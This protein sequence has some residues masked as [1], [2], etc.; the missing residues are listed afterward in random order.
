MFLSRL[1]VPHLEAAIAASRGDL[2]VVGAKCDSVD[3]DLVA[4]EDHQGSAIG[5]IPYPGSVVPT[6][7]HKTLTVCTEGDAENAAGMA[8]QRAELS[9]IRDVPHRHDLVH[10]GAGDSTAVRTESDTLERRGVGQPAQF[11]AGRAIPQSQRPVPPAVA[12]ILSSGLNAT[13]PTAAWWPANSKI[14]LPVAASQIFT[15]PGF[16][17]FQSPPADASCR[18]LWL[19]ATLNTGCSC[20]LK[21][22]GASSACSTSQI[23]TV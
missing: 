9:A 5:Q 7:G 1:A 11:L 23:L 20:P 2:R 12:T 10:A 13:P 17:N 3:D 22:R 16:R 19:N 15:S 4:A 8:M 18:P 14:S 6:A 21:V